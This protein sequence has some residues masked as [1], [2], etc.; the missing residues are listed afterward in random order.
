MAEKNNFNSF[1]PA[2]IALFSG[3]NPGRREFFG[4]SY[5]KSE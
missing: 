3:A 4:G 1:I 5:S 2:T